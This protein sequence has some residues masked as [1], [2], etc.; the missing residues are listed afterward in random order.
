MTALT[1]DHVTKVLNFNI[2]FMLN[3]KKPITSTAE[4]FFF[5]SEQFIVMVAIKI[6]FSISLNFSNL[7]TGAKSRM[8]DIENDV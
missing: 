5:F 7:K 1:E 4:N 8:N 2:L 3:L 6:D